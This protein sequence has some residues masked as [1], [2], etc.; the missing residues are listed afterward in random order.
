MF[1]PSVIP[2]AIFK[3]LTGCRF[4]KCRNTETLIQQWLGIYDDAIVSIKIMNML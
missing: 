1:P 2:F 3:T 4:P